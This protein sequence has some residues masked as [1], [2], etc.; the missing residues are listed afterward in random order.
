MHLLHLIILG[1]GRNN[2]WIKVPRECECGD[3]GTGSVHRAES[4]GRAL[5]NRTSARISTL[6]RYE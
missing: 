3:Y 2:I 5:V 1:H 6:A 4:A